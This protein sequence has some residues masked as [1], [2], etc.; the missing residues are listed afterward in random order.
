MSSASRKRP[1]RGRRVTAL[2]KAV[3]AGATALALTA[4]AMPA[5]AAITS[6][7]APGRAATVSTT[8]WA[9]DEVFG[10]RITEA[11]TPGS[12]WVEAVVVD[13]A[14]G[15]VTI[16]GNFDTPARNLARF[17]ADGTPDVAFNRAVGSS[18]NGTVR[19]IAIDPRNDDLVVGGSFSTPSQG[20]ARFSTN[21]T[22]D[23]AFNA[24]VGTNL[25]PINSNR[26]VR[27]IA[28]DPAG[29]VTVG[30]LFTVGEVFM[31]GYAQNL[32]RFD[33]GGNPD[34]TFN[35][36]IG[37]TFARTGTEDAMVW[38]VELDA[39]TGATTLGGS[40]VIDTDNRFLAR[41]DAD[42]ALDAG[43]AAT[44]AARLSNGVSSL[45]TYPNGDLLA[46]GNFVSSF[47]GNNWWLMARFAADGTP[48]APFNTAT[49]TPM[50]D[51]FWVSSTA[52][53]INIDPVTGAITVGNGQSM[54]RRSLARLNSDGT[55]DAEFNT[56]ID[57]T[58][59]GGQVHSIATDPTGALIVG[60]A[61]R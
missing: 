5:A 20:L 21:G 55:P 39:R 44:P 33:A 7:T 8:G 16:G 15:A 27:S 10:A 52:R 26:G 29:V 58:V 54:R 48:N 12:V 51:L 47:G 41:V 24:A 14:T 4:A 60:G 42:G 3:I 23:A 2:G 34:V 36:A 11:L 13:P 1:M 59:I 43:F 17:H 9:V 46:G 45:A 35:T 19:S 50:Q 53:A 56:A 40:F 18:L 37:S 25:G 57:N 30:G 32:A 38:A 31:A 6:N 61:L 49:F 28:L 22:P